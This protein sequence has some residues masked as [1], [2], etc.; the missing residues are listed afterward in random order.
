MTTHI[1]KGT[2]AERVVCTDSTWLIITVCARSTAT[3]KVG[4]QKGLSCT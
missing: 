4:R 3:V 2:S 1:T